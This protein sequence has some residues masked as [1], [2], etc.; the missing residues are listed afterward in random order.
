MS[1]SATARWSR[2]DPG[3][4][5]DVTA[6]ER[7][8]G[9]PARPEAEIRR[10]LASQSSLPGLRKDMRLVKQKV[11]HREVNEPGRLQIADG[12]LRLAGKRAV[13]LFFQSA[14]RH[15]ESAIR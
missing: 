3:V 14:I 15:L 7:V 6:G 1:I 8:F 2:A 11:V 4:P 10:I 9:Y 12:G 5:S 13:G